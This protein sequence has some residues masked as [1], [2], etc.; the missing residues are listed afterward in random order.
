MSSCMWMTQP[1]GLRLQCYCSETRTAVQ[2]EPDN[3]A[4]EAYERFL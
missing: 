1:Q 2:Y 3:H 4:I